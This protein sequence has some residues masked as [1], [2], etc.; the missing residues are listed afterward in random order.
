[1]LDVGKRKINNELFS[2]EYNMT[3]NC[4]LNV[5]SQIIPVFLICTV[6]SKL[7]GEVLMM[8][9]RFKVKNSSLEGVKQHSRIGTCLLAN[10]NGQHKTS[11]NTSSP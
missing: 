4:L 2:L 8:N 10:V 1:M 9:G 7:V 5:Y 3:E 6:T 11:P